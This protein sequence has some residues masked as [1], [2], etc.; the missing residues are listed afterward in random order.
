MILGILI[1]GFYRLRSNWLT[2]R[3][4]SEFEKALEIWSPL[5]A[6]HRNTPRTIKRFGNRVRYFVMLQQG[7]SLDKTAWAEVLSQIRAWLRGEHDK[8]LSAQTPK[9]LALTESRLIALSAFHEALPDSWEQALKTGRTEGEGQM[10]DRAVSALSQHQ[11][12]FHQSWP[13]GDVEMKT[14]KRLLAGIR[15]PGD[16]ETIEVGRHESGEENAAPSREQG[17]ENSP[18]SKTESVHVRSGDV[19][20]F[21]PKP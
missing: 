14:F 20:T 11:S 5:V 18:S 15:M 17:T 8:E 12:E 10:A 1:G 21:R 3:D 2:V 19:G 4:S 7:E 13:P 9:T 6:A 16:V